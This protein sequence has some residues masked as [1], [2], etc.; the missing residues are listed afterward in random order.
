[1]K[2]ANDFFFQEKNYGNV[3]TRTVRFKVWDHRGAWVFKDIIQT[4][5]NNT[6]IIIFAIENM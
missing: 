1:M 6:Y 3:Y 2:T 5:M 4:L